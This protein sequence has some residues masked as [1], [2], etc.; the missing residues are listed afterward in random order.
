MDVADYLTMRGRSVPALILTM[1]LVLSAAGCRASSGGDPS[2]GSGGTSAVGA[3]APTAGPPVKVCGTPPCVRFVSRG[4]TKTL[5]STLTDHPLISAVAVH[6]AIGVLCGGILCLLGEGVS[7]TYVDQAAKSAADQ[8]ACLK[9]SILPD[10]DRW[11]LV[12]LSASN[13][14]PYCT[15]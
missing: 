8:H 4:D 7:T 2:S 13:Q 5:S 10:Q 6:V 11:K 1:L 3:A 15:N 9:V 12:N 14:S